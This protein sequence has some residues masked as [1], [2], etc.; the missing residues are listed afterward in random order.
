MDMEKLIDRT[1]VLIEDYRDVLVGRQ[2]IVG[3]EEKEQTEERRRAAEVVAILGLVGDE[4]VIP[5]T[6]LRLDSIDA[7][8]RRLRGGKSLQHGSTDLLAGETHQ[9][10]GRAGWPRWLQQEGRNRRSEHRLV[11]TLRSILPA[12]SFATSPP[13]MENPAS[14]KSGSSSSVRTLCRSSAKVS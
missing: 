1:I 6:G 14:A 8:L 4:L 2:F 10:R 11:H 3:K 5:G 12:G 9:R 13:P 7:R